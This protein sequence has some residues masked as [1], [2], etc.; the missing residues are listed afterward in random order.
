MTEP[1]ATFRGVRGSMPVSGPHTNR[2]GGHTIC[3]DIDAGAPARVLI[4]AGTGIAL[5]HNDGSPND[6]S[7]YHVFF[8]HYHWD[9][10][11]G[12]LFFQPLY[13]SANSF[14]F[15]GHRWGEMDSR[16]AI[17]GA[18]RPPWFPVPIEETAARKR[19]VTIGRAAL[20]V[21][22]L[23]IA[24]APLSHPQGVTA[25]R[26]DGP[27][28]SMVIATDSERG[29]EAAD[30]TLRE[31]AAGADVL[32]H[33]AQYSPEE[34]ETRRIGWGHSTW[35]QAAEAAHAVGAKELILVSHDPH[36]T[37][38]EIDEFVAGARETF[39]ATRAAYEGMQIE[40]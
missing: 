20:Q 14:T 31:L 8:T 12:L 2:Y 19:Y 22:S 18:L 35:S 9:H 4:D 26:I 25:Y 16:E 15:Y 28:R 36:R 5:V 17:E 13:E 24:A 30:A 40:L 34:Y 38:D 6:V 27:N 39:R 3:I 1:L 7:D 10:I 11:Q 29:D 37:D 32:V 23:H 33:D 21:G